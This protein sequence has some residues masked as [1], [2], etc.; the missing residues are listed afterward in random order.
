VNSSKRMSAASRA[1][2]LAELAIAIDEAQRLAWR[3]GVTEAKSSEALELYVR[4]EAARV[5]VEALRRAARPAGLSPWPIPAP[6]AEPLKR[7]PESP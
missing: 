2:W 4:L 1:K 7:V 3:V 6:E 5:E